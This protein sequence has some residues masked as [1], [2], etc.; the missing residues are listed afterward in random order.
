MKDLGYRDEDE[1]L[2]AE[3]EGDRLNVTLMDGRL[4]SVPVE[5]YPFLSDATPEQR[6]QS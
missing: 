2:A 4:I 1:P 5:W 6:A 3:F